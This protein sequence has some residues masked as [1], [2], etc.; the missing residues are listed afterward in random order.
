MFEALKRAEVVQQGGNVMLRKAPLLKELAKRFL[1]HIQKQKLAGSLDADTVYCYRNGWRLLQS[2][3]VAHMRLGH[4]GTS[5]AAVLVFPGGPSNANQALRTL[6]RMLSYAADVGVLRGVPRIKLRK[7]YGREGIITPEWEALLLRVAEDLLGDILTIIF[8]CGMRPEE[9]MRMKPEHIQWDRDRLLVPYGKSMRS[10]RYLPLSNR[11][12]S[13]LRAR[14]VKGEWVFPAESESGHRA[15]ITKAWHATVKVAN[16]EALLRGIP[17][18][19][20]TIVPYSARHT[21]ATRY[22]DEGGDIASLMKLLGH[23]SL[24]VT[25]K[26]LHPEVDKAAEI[27]NKRNRKAVALPDIS[28]DITAHESWVN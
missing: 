25:Q 12:R 9:V 21:F 6:R 13:L 24:S 7:E 4:I 11:M 28:P 14:Q 18:I 20:S 10:K 8:D 19:P 15:T 27:V 22:L 26:Y 23:S 1:E 5:E 17:P 3:E 2:T 16:K